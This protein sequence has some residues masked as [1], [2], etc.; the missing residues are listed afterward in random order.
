MAAYN[1]RGRE[2]P[3]GDPAADRS[4][5]EGLLFWAA[6]VA[7]TSNNVFSSADASGPFRRIALMATCSTFRQLRSEEAVSELILGVSD[8]LDDPGLCPPE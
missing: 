2:E 1:P 6:W 7:H 8:L 3:T 5:E 4:R